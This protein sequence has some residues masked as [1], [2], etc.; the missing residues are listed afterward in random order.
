MTPKN[1]ENNSKEES[2]MADNLPERKQTGDA[3]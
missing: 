3:L 2:V 1:L